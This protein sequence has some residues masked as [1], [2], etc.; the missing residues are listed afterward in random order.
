MSNNSVKKYQVDYKCFL[1]VRPHRDYKE[2][3]LGQICENYYE[4][5][6]DKNIEVHKINYI[7]TNDFEIM[8]CEPVDRGSISGRLTEDG[9]KF[10]VNLFE[11]KYPI[12]PFSNNYLE[13]TYHFIFEIPELNKT[14][15]SFISTRFISFCDVLISNC[16]ERCCNGFTTASENSFWQKGYTGEDNLNKLFEDSNGRFY[17]D[18]KLGMH[19]EF[20]NCGVVYESHIDTYT[21]SSLVETLETQWSDCHYSIFSG[22]VFSMV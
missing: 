4:E 9:S 19:K 10:V 18:M 7:M 22:F 3:N 12:V 16:D 21:S 2:T 1:M 11:L 8:K 6:L 14:I 20:F 13:S 5:I 15:E 17:F